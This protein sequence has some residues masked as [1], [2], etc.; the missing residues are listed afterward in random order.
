MVHEKWVE[1]YGSTITYK[2]F[3][4]N[5]LYTLDAK[6]L[7]HVLMNSYDYQKPEIIRWNLKNILGSGWLIFSLPGHY[8]PHIIDFSG[9]L[10]QEG[11]EH[12]LQRKVMV[13]YFIALES[14]A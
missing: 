11:D 8:P 5:R 12:K 14:S 6:A 10:V 2:W 4:E 1:E 9:I 13:R 3:F 7:N